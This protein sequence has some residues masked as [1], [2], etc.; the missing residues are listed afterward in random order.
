M[1]TANRRVNISL[2]IVIPITTAVS[3]SNAPMIAVGVEPIWR[4]AITINTKDITVGTNASI[5][6]NIHIEEVVS[7]CKWLLLSKND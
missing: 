4:T 1:P 2:N 5:I 6:A 7:N 3:G